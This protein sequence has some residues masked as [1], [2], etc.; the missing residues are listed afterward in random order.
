MTVYRYV[1][2]GGDFLDGVPARDLSADDTV[3]RVLE[4]IL[5]KNGNPVGSIDMT[6]QAIEACGLYE[7]VA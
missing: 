1:G 2:K 5:D 7:K 6:V 3:G 4:S